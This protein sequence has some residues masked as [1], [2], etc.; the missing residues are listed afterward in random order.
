[1]F[2]EKK[3]I[4]AM[5]W[6]FSLY[7]IDDFDGYDEEAY[8][9]D[10]GLCLEE[11]VLALR[12]N[13]QIVHEYEVDGSIEFAFKYKGKE[14]FSQRAI[15]IFSDMEVGASSNQTDVSYLTELWLLEDMSFAVTHCIEMR[16][17]DG[18]VYESRHRTF[19]KKVKG[20]N[21]LFFVPEDL[22]DT[23]E[24]TC[25]PI[26]ESEATIYEL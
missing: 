2:K 23:L 19:V 18:I 22:I 11:V 20:R 17:D 10:F 13:A 24:E 14:L 21:D 6:L 15:K 9:E 8:G 26:W 3:M 7:A 12:N 5:K 16:H 1:M 25:V 4:R